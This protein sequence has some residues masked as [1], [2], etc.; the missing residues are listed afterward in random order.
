[1]NNLLLGIARKA[2]L[3]V[4]GE[5]SV[6]RAVRAYQARVIFSAADASPNAVHRAEQLAEQAGC[7]HVRLPATKEELGA[8]LGQG[9]PAILALTE[10][11]LAYKYVLQLSQERPEYTPVAETL[12]KAAEEAAQRRKE[13]AAQRRNK[14]TGKRRTK[15]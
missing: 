9:T 11:G 12:R 3:L 1:M 5:E 6:T 13:A 7:P 15:Q 8:L 10:E 14:R 2:G 4:T